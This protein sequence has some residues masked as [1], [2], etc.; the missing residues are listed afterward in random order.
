[1]YKDKFKMN[2]QLFAEETPPTDDKIED[3]TDK[4]PEETKTFTQEDINDIVSKRLE[5]ERA[6][7]EKDYK[8]KLATE[9]AEAEKLAK[10]SEAERAKAIFEKQQAEF[11]TERAKFQREKIELQVTKELASKGLPIT[12]AN[13]LVT[14]DADTSL[15][16]INKFE[17][18]WQEAL[19][20]AVDEKLK[21]TSPKRQET[22]INTADGVETFMK[23]AQEANIRK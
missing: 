12:F 19:D 13:L 17:K 3:E 2:L 11:E 22:Q 10:L 9:T 14:N 6:K 23:M 8:E 4:A 5:R 16:N 18:D 21:T 15:E 20:K 7:F 1:M